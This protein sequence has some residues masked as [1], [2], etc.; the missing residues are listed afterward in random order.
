MY[1]IFTTLAALASLAAALPTTAQNEVRDGRPPSSFKLQAK[2]KASSAKDV[3]SNKNDL[4][5]YSYHTGAGLGAATFNND[6]STA[7]VAS[8]NETSVGYQVAFTI[9][10][11]LP[12]WPLAVGYGPYQTF[13]TATISVA[14]EIDQ[15]GFYFTND[16]LM[17]NYTEFAGWAACDWWYKGSPSLV[18]LV[19]DADKAGLPAT[20]SEINLVAVAA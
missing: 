9:G 6:A 17:W 10:E 13:E 8:L 20:C 12:Q 7:P 18:A 15:F 16:G 4:Y 14:D 1:T 5:L 11:D 19:Q 2:V 3:G